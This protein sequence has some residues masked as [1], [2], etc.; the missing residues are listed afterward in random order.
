MNDENHLAGTVVHQKT[1]SGF[2]KLPWSNLNLND[3]GGGSHQVPVSDWFGNLN[4][5]K[6]MQSCTEKDTT[7]KVSWRVFWVYL[8][9]SLLSS[10]G[11]CY[12]RFQPSSRNHNE[13]PA[14]KQEKATIEMHWRWHKFEWFALL[15]PHQHAGQNLEVKTSASTV[16]VEKSRQRPADLGV[17]LA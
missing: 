13:Q 11:S 7:V 2:L 3:R 8:R 16:A 15:S 9:Y 10:K 17:Q 4:G 6:G 5:K 1:F 14:N 12:R